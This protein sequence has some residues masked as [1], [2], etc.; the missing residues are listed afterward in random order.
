MADEDR[1]LRAGDDR[2]DDTRISTDPEAIQPIRDGE[3][4]SFADP[5]DDPAQAEWERTIAA[6][7]GADLDTPTATGADP[8][9]LPADD[10]EVPR[11]DQPI[12]ELQPESQESDPLLAELGDD[13]EG[14]LSV[15]DV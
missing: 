5:S 13:G 6:D 12:S 11:A 14:D 2:A 10:D 7:S 1:D 15:N 9:E 3:A 4:T 8:D